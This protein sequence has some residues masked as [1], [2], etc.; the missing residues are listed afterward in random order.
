MEGTSSSL[1]HFD[2][3]AE[4]ES[5]RDCIAVTDLKTVSSHA[6]KRF[7]HFFTSAKN[8]LFRGVLLRLFGFMLTSIKPTEVVLDIDSVVYDND[9][10]L[11]REGSTPTYKKVKGFQL[12]LVK[13][14]SFIV[15]ADFRTGSAHCNRGNGLK[16]A[17]VS[18][19]KVIRKAL[20]DDISIRVTMDGRSANSHGNFVRYSGLI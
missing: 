10:A 6:I 13:W 7:F 19:V 4:D 20:G 1:G 3:L 14:G 18:L 17:F 16:Y 9:D 15:C 5:Y 8:R 11:K 12:L 2:D